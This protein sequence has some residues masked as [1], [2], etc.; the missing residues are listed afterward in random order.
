VRAFIAVPTPQDIRDLATACS[1]IEIT[2]LTGTAPA[3]AV[4]AAELPD[5]VPYAWVAGEA[6]MVR[7]VRRHLLTERGFAARPHYFGGYWRAGMSEDA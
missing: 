2:W 1:D 5:G 3:E 7:A 6:A 4:R